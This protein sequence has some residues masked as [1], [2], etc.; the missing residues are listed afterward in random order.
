MF[1]FHWQP[2]IPHTRHCLIAPRGSG[3]HCD[4]AHQPY[5]IFVFQNWGWTSPVTVSL[6]DLAEHPVIFPAPIPSM[7]RWNRSLRV[8]SWVSNYL[9]SSK[10]WHAVAI[11]AVKN[12]VRDRA[13][14]KRKPQAV[15]RQDR[16]LWNLGGLKKPS[17]IAA[18]TFLCLAVLLLEVEFEEFDVK[19]LG[20]CLNI[21]ML[22]WFL[23]A[24][25]E[26]SWSISGTMLA[27]QIP[28]PRKLKEVSLALKTQSQRESRP[29]MMR[30]MR[31]FAIHGILLPHWNSFPRAFWS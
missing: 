30:A 19:F 28:W 9:N 10:P 15:S 27:D 8:F 17:V 31:V 4:Y 1:N 3:C 24:F 26:Q 5:P 16:R 14:T 29:Q 6:G 22:G 25:T 23:W 21:C 7:F 11:V 20:C 18:T 12:T 2:W 13:L